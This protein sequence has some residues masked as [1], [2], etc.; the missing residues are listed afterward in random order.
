MKISRALRRALTVAIT[1]GVVGPAAACTSPPPPPGD[2]VLVGAGDIAN[3]GGSGDDATANLLDGIAGTVFTLGDNAYPNGSVTDYANCY[4]PTWGRHRSRTRPAPG[5]HEY[6]TPGAAGYFG[7]FGSAAGDPSKGYYSYD[8]GSWHVVVLNSNCAEVGGC[9][10]GSPQES[11]LRQDLAAST[12]PCTVAYWHHPLFT[13]GAQHGPETE[14]RPIYQALYDAN[15]EVVMS[16][17]NHEYERFA[18]Q[19]PNGTA[20]PNRGIREFVVGTGGES[21]YD[22]GAA[23]PNSEVRNADTFGVLRLSLHSNSYDWQFVPESGTSFTDAGHG[24]C[25]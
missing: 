19:D 17:H 13:S 15:A 18:P 20:D 23:Q 24:T 11:W 12:K 1:L 3:C 21:H 5:N 7:Y 16:G 8:L 14:M 6:N 25:H 22:F 2:A 10:G 4:G 9:A